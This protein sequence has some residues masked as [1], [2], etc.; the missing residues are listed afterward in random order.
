MFTRVDLRAEGLRIPVPSTL[1]DISGGGCQLHARTMLK[2][3]IAVEFDLPRQ[4]AAPLRLSGE[5]VKVSYTAN[6]RTFRY[7]VDF[8]TLT[9]VTRDELSRFIAM[10]QRKSIALTKRGETAEIRSG[11]PP[12]RIQELR[13]AQRVEVNFPVKYSL[14]TGPQN[15]EGIAIDVSTGGMRMLS[16]QVLRQEWT[17]TLRIAFPSDALRLARAAR[18]ERSHTLIPFRE[19]KV[20][21]R[22]LPGIKQTRGKYMQSLV[23]VNP[24]PLA[25]NEISRFV[26][27]TRLSR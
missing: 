11:R 4:A 12:L 20:T 23:W 24:D 9:D 14:S 8:G 19:I 3:H 16:E 18:G 1:V 13:S 7:G 26:D 25:T 22:P 17:V 10:E 27:A 6:D 15:Y 2:P 5:L 21:A